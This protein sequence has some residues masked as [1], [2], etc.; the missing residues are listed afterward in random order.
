V[1]AYD[2]VF[3]REVTGGHARFFLSAADVTEAIDGDEKDPS[4]AISR[5]EAGRDYAAAVYR[6]EDVTKRYEDL[7]ETLTGLPSARNV[8]L[9]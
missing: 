8:N 5:A 9:G 1:T 4:S 2:V 7:F 6:W 3:N